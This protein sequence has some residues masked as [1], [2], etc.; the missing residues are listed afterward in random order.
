MWRFLPS[1]T[2]PNSVEQFG[3]V[4]AEAMA[5]GVPVIGSDSGAI[6]EVVGEGGLIVPEGDPE[7]LAQ[8]IMKMGADE[9]L[10]RR[11]SEWG[12]ERFRSHYSCEAYAHSVVNFCLR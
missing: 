4:L 2:T 5:C 11:S 12:R 7:A 8:A 1:I 10:R 9:D 3:A 6:P